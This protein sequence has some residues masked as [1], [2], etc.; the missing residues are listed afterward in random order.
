MDNATALWTLASLAL[1]GLSYCVGLAFGLGLLF[2]L[3]RYLRTPMPWPGAVTPAPE[4]EGG[5]L[6][7][8]LGNVVLFPRLFRADRWLWAGAW[9]FHLALFLILVRHLRYFTYPVPEVAVAIA[10]VSMRSIGLWAGYIFG[11]AALYLFWRRLA[12][13]RTLYL[14]GLP[15][16]GVLV[17]LGL[18]AGSGLMVRYWAHVYLV[19]VKAFLLGLLTLR[20]VAPP[21]HPLFLLH[22]LFVL[23]LMLYFPFSKLLHAGG[24]LFSPSLNQPFTVQQAG[25]PYINRWDQAPTGLQRPVGRRTAQH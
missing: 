16:Y 10:G 24:I 7:R 5:A 21:A 25:R 19:D 8:L 18:V 23:A 22:Y 9:A 11:L 12:L 14:S 6:L 1:I 20:P 4:S 15:D 13:P 3:F 2:Q 17:L